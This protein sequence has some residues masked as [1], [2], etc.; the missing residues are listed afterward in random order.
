MSLKKPNIPYATVP[1]KV[2]YDSSISWK[3]KGL[4]AF[5]LAKPD[6]WDFSTRRIA[7]ESTTG[8]DATLS[9]LQELETAGYISRERLATGRVIYKLHL[10]P[11]TENPDE[12][13]EKPHPENPKLGKSLLGETRTVRNKYY[14]EIKSIRN[15]DMQSTSSI[16]E[17]DPK[18]KEMNESI[19][20]VIEEFSKFN[21]VCKKYYGNK[22]QRAA[23]KSLVESYGLTQVLKVI[24]FLPTS[25]Q[26]EYV[27]VITTPLQLDNKWLQLAAALQ[28]KKN[29]QPVIL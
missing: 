14:K 15:K 3:A 23:A 12:D 9:G 29:N 2:L 19:V 27:P 20:K 26:M 8:V 25:N 10:K 7:K 28:K 17:I 24:G 22:T 6:G 11:Y 1:N 16:A 4:Y 13:S 5:L 21:P 18:V